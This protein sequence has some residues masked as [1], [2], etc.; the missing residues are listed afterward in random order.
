M[1]FIYSNQGNDYLLICLSVFLF[2]SLYIN[3]NK[4]KA[5]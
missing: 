2:Q 4:R 3:T 1:T 5:S